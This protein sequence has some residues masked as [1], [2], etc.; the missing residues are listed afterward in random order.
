MKKIIIWFKSLFGIYRQGYTYYVNFDDIVITDQ[1]KSSKPK[2]KK[3]EAKYNYFL[4]TNELPSPIVLKR[5]FTLV[6]GYISYLICESYGI[7]KVPVYFE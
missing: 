1:F 2:F 3:L 4:N 7:G 5:D 6:D